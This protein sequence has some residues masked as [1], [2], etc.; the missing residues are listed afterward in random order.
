A[1]S[2]RS[3]ANASYVIRSF[4]QPPA[5]QSWRQP[6]PAN[7][8]LPIAHPWPVRSG[9]RLPA[10][11]DSDGS[12]LMVIPLASYRAAPASCLSG[13]QISHDNDAS[14]ST[15]SSR[16]D[17]NRR[18]AIDSLSQLLTEIANINTASS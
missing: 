7:L 6:A 17:S 8:G 3:S 2:L 11:C 16:N 9:W 10:G 15:S 14:S 13:K 1:V 18:A 5:T 4:A 12:D